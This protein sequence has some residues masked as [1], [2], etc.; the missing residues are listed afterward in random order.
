MRFIKY[1][2]IGYFGM[3]LLCT[4]LVICITVLDYFDGDFYVKYI[5]GGSHFRYVIEF[6]L[7]AIFKSSFWGVPCAILIAWKVDRIKA[8]DMNNHSIKEHFGIDYPKKD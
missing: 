7:P 2:L 1:S 8:N 3:A 6:A 5:Y 4:V